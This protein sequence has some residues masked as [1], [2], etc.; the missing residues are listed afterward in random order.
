MPAMPGETPA[1]T[2][3]L[4]SFCALLLCGLVCFCGEDL[5]GQSFDE[6]ALSLPPAGMSSLYI[7]MYSMGGHEMFIYLQLKGM[8]IGSSG[9]LELQGIINAFARGRMATEN[10]QPKINV[11][12]QSI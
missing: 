11:A 8:L 2:L 12:M 9:C 10:L 1:L 6:K 3:F 5:A 7:L 4:S